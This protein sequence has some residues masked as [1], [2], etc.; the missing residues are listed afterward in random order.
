MSG[1][2]ARADLYGSWQGQ[3]LVLD[4]KGTMMSF[5]VDG[6]AKGYRKGTNA[7]TE[8]ATE[9]K[10]SF[11]ADRC[12]LLL[13]VGRARGSCRGVRF[14]FCIA[15]NSVGDL[16]RQSQTDAAGAVVNAALSKR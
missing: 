5:A 15:R 14:A 4:D 16:T 1:T 12:G 7:A 6:T 2:L 11:R 9:P 10:S 13:G 3:E 8:D